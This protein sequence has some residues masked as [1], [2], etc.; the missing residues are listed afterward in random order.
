[1]VKKR[2]KRNV[3]GYLVEI[4]RS[5]YKIVRRFVVDD[6]LFFEVPVEGCLPLNR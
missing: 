6:Q 4:E 5:H 1:M 2:L 3:E